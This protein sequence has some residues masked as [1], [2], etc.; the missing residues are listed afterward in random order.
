MYVYGTEGYVLFRLCPQSSYNGLQRD[1]HDLQNGDNRKKLCKLPPAF[2]RKVVFRF[3]SSC[4]IFSSEHEPFGRSIA[5]S[6]KRKR[7]SSS[8]FLVLAC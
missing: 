5:S 1:Y 4:S 3:C 6:K 7:D 8:S 2:L